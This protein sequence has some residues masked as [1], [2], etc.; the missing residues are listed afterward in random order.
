MKTWVFWL[1]V[2][3]MTARVTCY[4]TAT[5]HFIPLMVWKGLSEAAAATLLGAFAS[6][7]L[8]AHFLLGW[9]ADRVNKP[10]SWPHATFFPRFRCQPL[11]RFGLLATVAVHD[12]VHFSGRIVSH[13]LGDRGRFLVGAISRRSEA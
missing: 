13:R 6:I 2:I 12:N 7:N 4:S 10:N 1:L 5:V 3:S 9:I 11:C 8:V